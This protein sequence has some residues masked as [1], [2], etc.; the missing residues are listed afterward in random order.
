M[1]VLYVG[2]SAE[3]GADDALTTAAAAGNV[4]FASAATFNNT[5]SPDIVSVTGEAS[6]TAQF[7]I[8]G[9]SVTVTVP[10][11]FWIRVTDPDL[12]SQLF[13]EAGD[14]QAYL[15]NDGYVSY[16][17]Q[18]IVD[19][20]MIEL[21]TA[22]A[23]VKGPQT[24]LT[25]AVGEAAA[26][27]LTTIYLSVT[28]YTEISLTGLYTVLTSPLTE[29]STK[30]GGLYAICTNVS[31]NS[32]ITLYGEVFIT[33]DGVLTVDGGGG[34]SIVNAG[35]IN[36]QGT[37]NIGQ[38]GKLTN[39]ADAV[40]SNEGQITVGSDGTLE[41][42]GTI[43]NEGSFTIR[44]S[45]TLTNNGEIVNE[46]TIVIEDGGFLENNSSDTIVNYGKIL[47]YGNFY[48]GNEEHGTTGKIENEVGAYLMNVGGV[49][50]FMN[51]DGSTLVNYG[52]AVLGGSD[53]FIYS[54]SSVFDDQGHSAYDGGLITTGSD[55]LIWFI[56]S[57]RNDGKW[58]DLYIDGSGAIPNYTASGE[59]FAPWYGYA[60]NDSG[61]EYIYGVFVAPGITAIGD[62]SF[63]QCGQ[64][65]RICFYGAPPYCS[66][67][68]F[69]ETPSSFKF[70]YFLD[71]ADSWSEVITDNMWMGHEIGGY[72]A[73]YGTDPEIVFNQFYGRS[74][75]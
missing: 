38:M 35:T 6:Y 52:I 20:G 50:L 14:N 57:T 24:E 43:N 17:T 73:H 67:N 12:Y 5:W 51:E 75:N 40:L 63:Y 69:S 18:L 4:V 15:E 60:G 44:E 53:H 45:G 61:D 13:D 27:P 46:D 74:G 66:D 31:P 37:I 41:N 68:S 39:A 59:D 36:N 9:Y 49:S 25:V 72:S 22:P 33:A 47:N 34:G 54:N 56:M 21:E 26:A 3:P 70:L 16:G 29:D 8:S 32:N 42:N 19:Y 55:S 7:E 11:G 62:N 1:D 23:F 48:N 65:N 2:N 28:D 71:A 58:L 30:E 10:D 64:I